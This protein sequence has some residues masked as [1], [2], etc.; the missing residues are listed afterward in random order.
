M[1]DA[2]ICFYDGQ[3]KK[4]WVKMKRQMLERD[5]IGNKAAGVNDRVQA[6]AETR[7]DIQYGRHS[8]QEPGK[9]QSLKR[10]AISN[11]MSSLYFDFFTVIGLDQSSELI[12]LNLPQDTLNHVRLSKILTI[13]D[14]SQPDWLI[15]PQNSFNQ[16]FFLKGL[17]SWIA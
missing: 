14:S 4:V 11:V 9:H 12:E 13:M 15:T 7:R 10:G 2:G 1:I 5:I 8:L 3:T 16:K 17:D 6:G